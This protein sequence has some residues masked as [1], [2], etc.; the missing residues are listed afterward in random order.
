MQEKTF[1]K[2]SFVCRT[3]F[4][5]LFHVSVCIQFSREIYIG[6]YVCRTLDENIHIQSMKMQRQKNVYL[7][8]NIYP[9]FG[10]PNSKIKTKR[11]KQTL[12]NAPN[13][14]KIHFFHS[15]RLVSILG[16]ARKPMEKINFWTTFSH[17]HVSFGNVKRIS[18]ILLDIEKSIFHIFGPEYFLFQG[19]FLGDDCF[20][21]LQ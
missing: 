10:D 2:C 17:V 21:R 13:C 18:L 6:L 14:N 3:T 15:A 16:C 5:L 7:N 1:S 4:F 19:F 20:G 9:K 12:W 11:S 8:L